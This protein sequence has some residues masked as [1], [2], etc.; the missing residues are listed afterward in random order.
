MTDTFD[1]KP[2]VKH[3]EVANSTWYKIHAV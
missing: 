2:E 1:G 3:F